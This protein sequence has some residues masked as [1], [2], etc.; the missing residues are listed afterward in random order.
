MVSPRIPRPTP[1]AGARSTRRTAMSEAQLVL[2]DGRVFPGRRFGAGADALGEVV[3]NTCMTGYQE[4]LGD[5][6]YAGQIV[7]MT[8]PMIGNYGIAPEDFESRKPFVAGLA[9]REPSR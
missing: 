6:S 2:E 7:V 3:F 4:I 1:W 9:V 5:P 8:Y